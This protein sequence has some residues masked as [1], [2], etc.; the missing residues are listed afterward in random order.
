MVE[1]TGHSVEPLETTAHSVEPPET[2]GH[3]FEPPETTEHSF[4]ATRSSGGVSALLTRPVDADCLLV[5]GHGAGAGMRHPFMEALAA[6]LADRRIATFRYQFPYME[7]GRRRPDFQPV[8]LK[9][10]RSAVSAASAHRSL[11]RGRQHPGN[12]RGAHGR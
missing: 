9:T 12:H 8:L 11:Q 10:V 6:R 2:T 3:G 4:E 1:V 5:F 7:Q